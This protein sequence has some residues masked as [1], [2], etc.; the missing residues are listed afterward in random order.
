MSNLDK[1]QQSEQSFGSPSQICESNNTE[2][3]EF[4]YAFFQEEKKKNPLVTLDDIYSVAQK[5]F[6]NRNK[7][8]DICLDL[9]ANSRKH[10]RKTDK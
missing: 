7:S 4:M 10:K 2:W 6:I 1:L 3:K 9:I 5:K 8:C